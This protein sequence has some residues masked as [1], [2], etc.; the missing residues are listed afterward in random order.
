M[1]TEVYEL[2]GQIESMLNLIKDDFEKRKVEPVSKK[3]WRS[4]NGGFY[5]TVDELGQVCRDIDRGC[6]SDD[7]SYRSGI[8]FKTQEEACKHRS[9]GYARQRIF[10][11]LREAEGDYVADWIRRHQTKTHAAYD[12]CRKEIVLEGRGFTQD[13]EPQWY[14]SEPAWE[15]VRVSHEADL[16]LVWGID[17]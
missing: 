6:A 12:H 13:L 1:K 15:A 2:L 17:E 8:Y 5:H 3:R 4:E 10:D 16:L 14:S 9:I 7:H 11:A